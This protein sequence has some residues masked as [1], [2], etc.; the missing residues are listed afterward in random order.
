MEAV[1]RNT[2]SNGM[3]E[4]GNQISS[5]VREIANSLTSPA[6]PPVIAPATRGRRNGPRSSGFPVRRSR[7]SI[8]R[9]VRYL[10]HLNSAFHLC[11]YCQPQAL[12]REYFE[13]VAPQILQ[14]AV[15]RNEANEFRNDWEADQSLVSCTE[16][17]FRLYFDGTAVHVWNST[18]LRI[19][20]R[21]FAFFHRLED[22]ELRSIEDGMVVRFKSLKKAY[23]T[24]QHSQA[25]QNR[26]KQVSRRRMR[27]TNVWIT[28]LK[29]HLYI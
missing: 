25:D 6:C 20:S 11:L 10:S 4:F 7:G 26:Q 1:L 16:E 13:K 21:C 19:L 12:I 29:G 14:T 9:A 18:A 22:V 23:R 2:I 24:L 17:H 28:S 5:Q 3:Q 27:K 15:G 8:T